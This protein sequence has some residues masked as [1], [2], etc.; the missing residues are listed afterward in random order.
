[1]ATLNLM[2]NKHE[3]PGDGGREETFEEDTERAIV[4]PKPVPEIVDDGKNADAA[5]DDQ[6]IQID[7]DEVTAEESRNEP[8][9]RK[10]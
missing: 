2:P 1:M 4:L 7:E 5:F 10:Y 9:G 8:P 3:A 6:E